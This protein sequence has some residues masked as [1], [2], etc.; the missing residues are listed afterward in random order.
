MDINRLVSG[1]LGSQTGGAGGQ[2]TDRLR[3]VAQKGL[4]GLPQGAMGGAVG[5]VAAG[6][7]VSLLLGSKKARKLG[8]KA[9]T[10]GGMAVVGGLAYKAWRDYQGRQHGASGTVASP[11]A[12]LEAAPETAFDPAR[13]IDSAGGDMRLGLLRAMISAA[14]ADGHIDAAE[15]DKIKQQIDAAGLSGEEKGFVLDA[16]G[17]ASDPIAVARLAADE[18]QAAELYV[19]SALAIDIDTPA[20]RQYMDRLGDALRLPADLRRSLEAEVGQAKGA[21]DANF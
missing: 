16:M 21:V 10:Y 14:K 8:G 11:G 5:G 12:G 3:E 2:A 13:Q 20:E 7:L 19:A 6:G 18:P 1:I 15:H 17:Q 4:G 9:L